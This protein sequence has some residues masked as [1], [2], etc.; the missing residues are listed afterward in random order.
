MFIYHITYL[1]LPG[2]ILIYLNRIFSLCARPT[3][4]LLRLPRLDTTLHARTDGT[5]PQHED[6]QSWAGDDQTSEG[7][8]R[9]KFGRVS[10][11]PVQ[12]V[13][14]RTAHCRGRAL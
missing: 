9:G 6:D 11:L 3:R 14:T 4:M 8:H 13:D 12:G 5:W 1:C 10:S 7:T 2:I